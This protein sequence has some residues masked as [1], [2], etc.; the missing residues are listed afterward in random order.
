[1]KEGL[2]RR[3]T[4]PEEVLQCLQSHRWEPVYPTIQP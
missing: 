3:A 2:A 1:L 4:T